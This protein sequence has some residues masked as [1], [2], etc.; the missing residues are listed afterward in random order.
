MMRAIDKGLANSKVGLV[1]VT[2]ALLARLPKKKASLT[3]NFQRYSQEIGSFPLC[4]TQHMRRFAT[5]VY[6]GFKDGP[7]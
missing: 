6:A 1:L 2:P 3:K 7:R 5:W 4:I